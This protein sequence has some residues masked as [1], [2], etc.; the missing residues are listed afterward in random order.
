MPNVSQ[1]PIV[2]PIGEMYICKS[3]PLDSKYT[4]SLNVDQLQN[5]LFTAITS[6][7]KYH[8]IGQSFTRITN[9]KVRVEITANELE[10][11]NYIMI[12]NG[13]FFAQN[14][15]WYYC[16]IENKEYVNNVTTDIT[17]S[18]DY[19]LTYWEDFTIPRNFIEREHC[20]IADDVVGKNLVPENLELG[21]Y[22]IHNRSVLNLSNQN[23]YSCIIYLPNGTFTASPYLFDYAVYDSTN[24]AGNFISVTNTLPIDTP[25]GYSEQV[26]PALRNKFGGYIC[27][28]FI[29]SSSNAKQDI[30]T[31][32]TAIRKIQEM[33]GSIIGI[34]TIPYDMYHDNATTTSMSY[35]AFTINETSSFKNANGLDEYGL[36]SVKNKKLYNSPYKK[37]IVSNSNGENIEFKWELFST[38]NGDLASAI[39]QY[40]NLMLPKPTI[41]GYPMNYRGVLDDFESCITFDSFPQP[42]WS[43]DS[44]SSW[45]GQNSNAHTT[46]LITQ[47]I[48]TA[49]TTATGL[50]TKSVRGTAMS[51]GFGALGIGQCLAQTQTAKATP[52]SAHIESNASMLALLENRMGFVFYEVGISGYMAKIIDDYFELYGYACHEEKVPNFKAQSTRRPIWNYC[53][54]QNAQIEAQTGTRRGLPQEAQ[55]AIEDIFNNGITLWSDIA[56]VGNYNLDNHTQG[57]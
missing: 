23:L 54:M 49:L 27:C 41:I 43:E 12:K 4:H 20:A 22:V 46:S 7:Q 21:D 55:K 48:M 39:F 1:H 26:V 16:F 38:R 34:Y 51:A 28:L 19:L 42:S 25:V 45:L 50:A 17:F 13:D 53:K 15:K 3:V 30:E 44:Y 33:S 11:C 40:T 57:S 47:G 9:N 36:N 56:K 14:G 35:R 18:V 5:G 29:P 32:Q 10:E 37:I 6:Y 31:T 52:D 8:L 24:S 2:E